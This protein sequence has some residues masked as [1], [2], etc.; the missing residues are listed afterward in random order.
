MGKLIFMGDVIDSGSL[1]Q[2]KLHYI[3]AD[4]VHSCNQEFKGQILSPL[5]VTLGDEFQGVLR[6]INVFPEILAFLEEK[7]WRYDIE[8]NFRYALNMGEIASEVNENIAHG[9]L[10]T[11]LTEARKE[12]EQLKEAKTERF[13]LSDNFSH[14]RLKELVTQIYLNHLSEWKFKDRGLIDS[15]LTY[16]DYKVVAHQLEKDV[17]LMWRRHRNLGFK[18]Y[19]LKR[20][21]LFRV[22][23]LY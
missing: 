22:Y 5:T 23:G 14:H 13:V 4:L 20:E 10:G 21:A 8:I 19:Y 9:M 11:G 2:K 17:S 1:D 18:D 3:L 6:T 12:L 7:K 15:F 16:R